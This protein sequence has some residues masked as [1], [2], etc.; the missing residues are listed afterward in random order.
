MV[1]VNQKHKD[2]KKLEERKGLYDPAKMKKDKD[3]NEIFLRIIG[4]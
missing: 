2:W 4:H 1:L 3:F